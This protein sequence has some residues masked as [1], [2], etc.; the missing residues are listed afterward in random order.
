MTYSNWPIVE[1]SSNGAAGLITCLRRTFVTFR[2][3]NEVASDGGPEFTATATRQFLQ[4]WGVDH[5]L[6][7]VSFPHSNCRAEVGVKTVK[8]LIADN[9]GPNGDLDT[10]AF[11]RA[12]CSS[13]EIHPTETQN[14]HLQCASLVIQ[15]GISFRFLQ[16]DTL[17]T[18]N[19]ANAYQ[20]TPKD[21]LHWQSAIVCT[22]RTR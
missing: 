11:Q 15:S 3:P 10:D 20:N 21:Y 14:F 18:I 12:I 7:S 22:Y 1:R 8:R 9:T 6:S 13:T 19:K 5:R 4:D 2:I 17:P 16:E